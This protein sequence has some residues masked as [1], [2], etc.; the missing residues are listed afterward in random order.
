MPADLPLE[1]PNPTYV[2]LFLKPGDFQAKQAQQSPLFSLGHHL[3]R[4]LRSENTCR[5]GCQQEAA[6]FGYVLQS[7]MADELKV[8][9]HSATL[10]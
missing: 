1:A 4:Q 2:T 7:L 9:C 5:T 6:C 3:Q 10:A 8:A